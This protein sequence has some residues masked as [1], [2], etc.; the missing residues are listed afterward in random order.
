MFSVQHLSTE[1]RIEEYAE[2]IRKEVRHVHVLNEFRTIVWL[3]ILWTA[4]LQSSRKVGDTLSLVIPM[5]KDC[6]ADIWSQPGTGDL[7]KDSCSEDVF[8]IHAICAEFH[9]A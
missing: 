5:L 7:R 8:R 3:T 6:A 9:A 2:W 1:I 4:C